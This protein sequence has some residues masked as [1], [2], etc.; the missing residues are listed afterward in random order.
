MSSQ[1]QRTS[2]STALQNPPRRLQNPPL[3]PI[4]TDPL[5]QMNQ[6]TTYHPNTIPQP[7]NMMQPIPHPQSFIPIQQDTLIKTAASILEP[8]KPFDELDHS[9]TPEEYL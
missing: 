8:M 1:N 6:H 5:Y 7:I 4:S 2:Y 9:Y 3:S